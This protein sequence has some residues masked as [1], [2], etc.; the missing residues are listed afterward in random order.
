MVTKQ[1]E[2]HIKSAADAPIKTSPIC[3]GGISGQSEI[4]EEGFHIDD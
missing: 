3:A 2:M 1:V 4:F